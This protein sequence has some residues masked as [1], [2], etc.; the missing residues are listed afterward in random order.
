MVDRIAVI[1]EGRIVESGTRSQILNAPQHPYTAGLIATADLAN[2]PAG[3]RLPVL[4][5]FWKR[6]DRGH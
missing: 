5:D 4:D 1:Y 2:V 3:G 6:T